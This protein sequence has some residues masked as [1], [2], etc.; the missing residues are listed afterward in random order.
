MKH[1]TTIKTRGVIIAVSP[2]LARAIENKPIITHAAVDEA[3]MIEP[4]D[5]EHRLP[6]LYESSRRQACDM[7]GIEVETISSDGE[8]WIPIGP[9]PDLKAAAVVIK[10]HMRRK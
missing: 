1:L 8:P 9:D 6:E 7:F 10:R 5:I 2:E 3:M 4:T